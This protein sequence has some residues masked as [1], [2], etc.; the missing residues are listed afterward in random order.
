MTLSCLLTRS[1]SAWLTFGYGL[2]AAS[3]GAASADSAGGNL[4]MYTRRKR[5]LP[6]FH[7]TSTTS[8]PSERAT[9]SAASRTFSKFTRRLPGLSRSNAQFIRR[10]QKSGLAP[11][12][13]CDP[14][15]SEDKVYSPNTLNARHRGSGERRGPGRPEEKRV[16]PRLPSDPWTNC[17]AENKLN[18]RF[19]SG[20]CRLGRG[21]RSL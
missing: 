12:L 5:C 13:W 8:R 10:Q 2:G 11:T 16:A 1:Q 9:R 14:L 15:Q 18:L 4:S 19:G 3:S 7:S 6:I 17:L 21:R 20:S